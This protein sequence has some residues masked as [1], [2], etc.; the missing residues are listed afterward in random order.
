[1]ATIADVILNN[2][3]KATSVNKSTQVNAVLNSG[4]VTTTGQEVTDLLNAINEQ[5]VQS[6]ITTS[7]VEYPWAEGN[8]GDAS[9]TTATAL[10]V[11]IA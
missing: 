1:M 11:V 7:L 4:I 5:N 3:W 10:A 9:G 8:L 6:K 2:N